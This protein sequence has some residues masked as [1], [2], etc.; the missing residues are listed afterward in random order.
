VGFLLWFFVFGGFESTT[1]NN[2]NE[3]YQKVARDA[4]DQYRISLTS[5]DKIQICVQAGLVS[6][7]HLQAKND[8]AYRRWKSIEDADCTAAGMPRQ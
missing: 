4:E 5:G 3:I 7:S 8:E 6:A 1:N 2:L